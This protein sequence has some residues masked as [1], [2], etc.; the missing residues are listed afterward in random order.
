VTD[1]WEMVLGGSTWS[2]I[3][4]TSPDGNRPAPRAGDPI[5]FAPG[6]GIFMLAPRPFTGTQELWWWSPDAR[7]WTDENLHLP[8]TEAPAYS[9]SLAALD[10]GLLFLFA[11]AQDRLDEDQLFWE[12]WRG[13]PLP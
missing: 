10:H 7:A 12:T 13:S 1:V 4:D 3:A 11:G 9:M 5:V 6:L 2:R 8:R